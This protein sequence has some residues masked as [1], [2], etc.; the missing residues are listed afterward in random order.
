MERMNIE[1]LMLAFKMASSLEDLRSAIDSFESRVQP[2]TERLWLCYVQMFYSSLEKPLMYLQN[3]FPEDWKVTYETKRYHLVDPSWNHCRHSTV[4][5]FWSDLDNLTPDQQLMVDDARKHGLCS[6]VLIPFHGRAGYSLF[7]IMSSNDIS[8]SRDNL[9]NAKRFAY[10]ILPYMYEAVCRVVFGNKSI[11][12]K[13]EKE[14]LYWIA[15]GLTT[16]QVSDKLFISSVTVEHHVKNAC[17]KLDAKNRTQCVRI[18]LNLGL[19]IPGETGFN[20]S[21]R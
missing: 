4:P 2:G 17:A 21:I 13:R 11:L 15:E 18:A 16:D 5:F 6:G 19:I 20:Y 8:I 9:E 14:V 1:D 10:E 3:R 12:S 7:W